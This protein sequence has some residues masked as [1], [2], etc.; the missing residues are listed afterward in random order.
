MFIHENQFKSL[1]LEQPTNQ[2]ET[3]AIFCQVALQPLPTLLKTTRMQRE[4]HA[5]S[6]QQRA[7]HCRCSEALNLDVSMSHGGVLLRILQMKMMNKR[8]KKKYENSV[9]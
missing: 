2:L 3:R 9:K 7:P 5:M 8:I 1:P 6:Q 4:T